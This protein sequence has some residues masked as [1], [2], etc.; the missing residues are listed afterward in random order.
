MPEG[1]TQNV[2]LAP[3]TTL[4]VGGP[5]EYFADVRT[6]KELEEYVTW[7]KNNNV[8]VTPLGGGSNVL[9]RDTGIQGLVLRILLSHIS[10]TE[11]RDT[12]YVTAGAGV[13]LD[14]LVEELVTKILWGIENLSGIPGNVGAVPIQNVGAYGVEAKLRK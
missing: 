13:V 2:N 8:R 14:A 12:V 5:A 3:F 6:L 9:I 4:G 11:E 1:I 7:A 10:I